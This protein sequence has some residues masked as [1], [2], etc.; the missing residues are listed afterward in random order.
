MG[1]GSK[2]VNS[3]ATSSDR[4]KMAETSSY[5]RCTP[6]QYIS[7]SDFLLAKKTA[8][9]S[10]EIVVSFGNIKHKSI[11][12]ESKGFWPSF[13]C[14][15]LIPG[16]T[17]PSVMWPL[18]KVTYINQK[19]GDISWKSSFHSFILLKYLSM[20]KN[21]NCNKL[22]NMRTTSFNTQ[23]LSSLTWPIYSVTFS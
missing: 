23:N 19:P 15:L 20:H 14:Y 11:S 22:H 2:V 4:K 21:P 18:K 13:C 3:L 17:E 7:F 8:N 12:S 1:H 5:H 16:C 9:L 6:S 10:P